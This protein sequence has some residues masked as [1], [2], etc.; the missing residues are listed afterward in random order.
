MEYIRRRVYIPFAVSPFSVAEYLSSVA[1]SLPSVAWTCPRLVTMETDSDDSSYETFHS[2]SDGGGDSLSSFEPEDDLAELGDLDGFGFGGGAPTEDDA[3]DDWNAVPPPKQIILHFDDVD[4][5]LFADLK[6][7]VSVVKTNIDNAKKNLSEDDKQRMSEHIQTFNCFMPMEFPHKLLQIANKIRPAAEPPVVI[8]EIEL[9]L[10]L[11]FSLAVYGKSLDFLLKHRSA[12]PYV[13]WVIETFAGEEDRA[14]KI[15]RWLDVFPNHQQHHGLCWDS[16]FQQNKDMLELE[17]IVTRSNSNMVFQPGFG[18][19]EDDDKM[20]NRSNAAAL[21]GWVRSKG[22]NSFGPVNNMVG[23]APSGFFAGSTMQLPGDSA[24]TVTRRLLKRMV[25]AE[26]DHQVD[27][28]GSNLNS[29]RG[30]NEEAL[31]FGFAP[32]VNLNMTSTVKRGPSLPF[33]FGQTKYKCRRPQRQIPEDGPR[34]VFLARCSKATPPSNL[35]LYRSGTGRCT[36]VSSTLEKMDG[37]HWNLIA[38]SKLDLAMWKNKLYHGPNKLEDLFPG[39]GCTLYT[40]TQRTPEWFLLRLFTFTSTTAL[41]VAQRMKHDSDLM[42]PEAVQLLHDD[43]GIARPC[44]DGTAAVDPAVKYGRYMEMSID[45]LELQTK[46]LLKQILAAFNVPGRSTMTD[47]RV[48]A[49]AVKSGPV[50]ETVINRS[51]FE[52]FVRS[53]MMKPRKK[54]PSTALG[55]ANEDN[56]L[57]GLAAFTAGSNVVEILEKPKEVGLAV[58]KG[59]RHLGTNAD[60]ASPAADLKISGEPS[61]DGAVIELKTMTTASTIRQAKQRVEH[62][63]D[64]CQL[65][66]AK[67]KRIVREPGYRLQTLH[68]AT[69]YQLRYVVFVVAS[70]TAIINVLLID[71][72]ES[73]RRIWEQLLDDYTLQHLQPIYG[74]C[75]L[76]RMEEKNLSNGSYRIEPE[77]VQVTLALWRALNAA[78]ELNDGPVPP[79][80]HLQPRLVSWWNATKGMVDVISRYLKHVPVHVGSASP[81]LVL[82]IRFCLVYSIN[83]CI[84]TKLLTHGATFLTR[85]GAGYGYRNFKHDIANKLSLMDVCMELAQHLRL[86]MSVRGAES[87]LIARSQSTPPTA[88]DERRQPI[89]ASELELFRQEL[90]NHTHFRA[91]WFQEN[92]SAKRIRLSLG[93]SHQCIVL[94]ETVAEESHQDGNSGE[95]SDAASHTVTPG[96]KTARKRKRNK[97]RKCC[98]LCGSRCPSY[99]VTCSV[100]MCIERIDGKP[101]CCEEFHNPTVDLE[102]TYH[103]RVQKS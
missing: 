15:L 6:K 74:D 21:L 64:R 101:A 57:S 7:Q 35:V 14:R 11:I 71:V 89:T 84:A 13:R 9:I 42:S 54:T 41:A 28:M 90:K 95:D 37:S 96:P 31:Q 68:H 76:P 94:R 66:D 62:K 70:G 18:L 79:L 77:T 86:P 2:A 25:D 59:K 102:R 78:V 3:G 26:E 20:R 91:K 65:G 29:D 97:G 51:E 48:M 100:P 98:V 88:V 32:E 67:F 45:Q 99:C 19:T 5:E 1:V 27:M 72:A 4:E 93:L 87:A 30:Y 36:M 17:R 92:E 60:G 58:R 56:I 73:K 22:I 23:I 61:P 8:R 38:K 46:K 24:L 63:V 82:V 103:A 10:R 33:K 34:T 16:P 69:V 53:T 44:A 43:L 40:A 75:G 50:K 81:A 85:T 83:T 39:C 55:T 80:R 47:K 12:F 52:E 49:R